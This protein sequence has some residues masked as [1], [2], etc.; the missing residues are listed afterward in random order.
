MS[1]YTYQLVFS[2]KKTTPNMSIYTVYRSI[3]ILRD[4]N[5]LI[6]IT[7]HDDCACTARTKSYCLGSNV[8]IKRYQHKLSLK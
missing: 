8:Q 2:E 5:Y 7:H 1:V 6:H 3:D 4:K